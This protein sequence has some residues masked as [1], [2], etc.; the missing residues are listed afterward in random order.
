MSKDS[1]TVAQRNRAVR[2]DALREQLSK[3][4]HLE[5]VI[6]LC[7]KLQDL[8]TEISALDRQ[9][10]KDVIDTKLKLVAKYLPDIKAVEITGDGG[11]GLT[12]SITENDAKL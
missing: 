7:T 8:D 10:L 3:Q 6:E 9:R 12:I 2:Q 4:K 1:R 11:G 5:H